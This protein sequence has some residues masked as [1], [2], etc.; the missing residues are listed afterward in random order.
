[1]YSF[2][3][4]SRRTDSLLGLPSRWYLGGGGMAAVSP[5]DTR[6]NGSGSARW[7]TGRVALFHFF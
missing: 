5:R 4:V 2:W 1:M 7:R 6:V 3:L